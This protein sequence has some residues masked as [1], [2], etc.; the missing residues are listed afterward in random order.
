MCFFRDQTKPGAG[1]VGNKKGFYCKGADLVHR[2]FLEAKF[3]FL[4]RDGRGAVASML[5][6]QPEHDVFSASLRWRL[7]AYRIRTLVDLNP[8]HCF[9]IRYESLVTGPEQMCR[10]LWCPFGLC[11]DAHKPKGHRSRARGTAGC[12]MGTEYLGLGGDVVTAG[13]LH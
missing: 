3:L 8:R 13:S 1:L 6:H 2:L 11:A 12:R 7:K 5:D 4:L 10:Q 9:V